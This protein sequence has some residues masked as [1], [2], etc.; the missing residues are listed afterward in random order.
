VV[1]GPNGLPNPNQYSP[2]LPDYYQ[3][4]DFSVGL[5]GTPT[6][7]TT[8]AKYGICSNDATIQFRPSP[9]GAYVFGVDPKLQSFPCTIS[10]TD[11]SNNKYQITVQK[12]AV[13]PTPI[14]PFFCQTNCTGFDPMVVSCPSGTGLVPPG[15]RCNFTNETTNT[16]ATPAP[17][18]GL[19]AREPLQPA[20]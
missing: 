16:S 2:P 4:F 19:A 3:Y 13:P 5:G 17:A 18:Y 10:L 12:A 8:W 14:W 6:M 1:G 20:P 15:N 11:S 9:N 7:K